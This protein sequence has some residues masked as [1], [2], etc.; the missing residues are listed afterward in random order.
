MIIVEGIEAP[1]HALQ[2]LGQANALKRRVE[3]G[4][5]D[6]LI[7]QGVQ[8]VIRDLLAA[9]E[10]N[11]LHRPG[12]HA[13][14][15][16]QNLEIR[17]FHITVHAGLLQVAAAEGFDIDA[18]CFHIHHPQKG[19]QQMS[20][21]SP[22]ALLQVLHALTMVLIVL[23]GFLRLTLITTEIEDYVLDADHGPGED[24]QAETAQQDVQQHGR[25]HNLPYSREWVQEAFFFAFFSFSG[26]SGCGLGAR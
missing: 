1:A 23:R 9:R 6:G 5:D 19:W 11:D 21:A 10:V 26:F 15:E 20:A 3:S 16:K 2:V 22:G 18:E 12:I 14:P 7:R 25:N 24:H 4:L 8:D 17:R 13:V